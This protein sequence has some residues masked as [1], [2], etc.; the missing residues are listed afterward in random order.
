[1]EQ[2]KEGFLLV[3]KP[4]CIT[5]YGCI[6][7]IKRLSS[8]KIKIGHAGTLDPFATGLLIVAVGRGATRLVDTAMRLDK[9]YIARGKLGE[10]TDTGDLTGTVLYKKSE[11]A[12]TED[13][14]CKAIGEFGDSYIQTPPVY[15]ALK[16]KGS[17]LHRLAR[18]K[19]MSEDELENIVRDKRRK[20]DLHNLQ[21]M[22]YTSPY[23][24]IKASVSHGT[25]IRALVSDIAENAGSCATTYSLQRTAIGSFSIDNAVGFSSLSTVDYVN[26]HIIP[27]DIFTQT[28]K[29]G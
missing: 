2:I 12:I 1:M 9:T 17:P 27:V 11:Q 23:F 25:Y 20:V 4:A 15:S 8:T 5:S 21:L 29:S 10:Y 28:I 7:Q 16:Y 6:D 3:N 13:M 22:E 18:E 26:E 24:I 19:T 14:L